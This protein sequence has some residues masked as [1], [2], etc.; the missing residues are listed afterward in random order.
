[1]SMACLLKGEYRRARVRVDKKELLM[2]Q[3]KETE[4]CFINNID[5]VV[6]DGKCTEDCSMEEC[7]LSSINDTSGAE[8][9]DDRS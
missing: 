4:H 3:D 9:S 5:V 8:Q 7:A 2:E 6:V 1:M